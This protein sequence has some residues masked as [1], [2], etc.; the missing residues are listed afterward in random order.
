MDWLSP[1]LNGS[2]SEGADA[3]LQ[4]FLL[5]RRAKAF[6]TK[7]E[8]QTAVSALNSTIHTQIRLAWTCTAFAGATPE[9]SPPNEDA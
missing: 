6:T 9:A 3:H 5:Q 4:A 1:G 2:V 8:Y 7:R